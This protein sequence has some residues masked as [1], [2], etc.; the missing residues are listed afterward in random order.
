MTAPERNSVTFAANETSNLP[1]KRQLLAFSSPST[2]LSTAQLLM[3]N[4]D[5]SIRRPNP[6]R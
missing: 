5:H 6:G 4:G 1:T 3:L 2:P